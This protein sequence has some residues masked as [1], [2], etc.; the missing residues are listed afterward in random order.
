MLRS[1]PTGLH[2]WPIPP[3]ATISICQKLFWVDSQ[4][5]RQGEVMSDTCNWQLAFL[6]LNKIMAICRREWPEV[7]CVTAVRWSLQ[8]VETEGQANSL[9]HIGGRGGASGLPMTL[10][11]W[12][13]Q[14]RVSQWLTTTWAAQCFDGGTCIRFPP[15]PSKH[16]TRRKNEEPVKFY[17][18]IRPDRNLWRWGAK[19]LSHSL[20]QVGFR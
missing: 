16:Q 17:N 4:P 5:A 9:T 2:M 10:T 19:R 13:T 20:V 3:A 18:P 6:N 8:C 14:P 1:L 12:E 15:H 7:D 11:I